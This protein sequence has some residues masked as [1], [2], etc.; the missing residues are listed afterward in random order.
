M[1][2]N[3]LNSDVVTIVRPMKEQVRGYAVVSSIFPRASPFVPTF[4]P[5][6]SLPRPLHCSE[7]FTSPITGQRLED[8]VPTGIRRSN[9][10]EFANAL[11]RMS[12]RATAGKGPEESLRTEGPGVFRDL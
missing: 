5:L 6:S 3:P 2:F 9:S 11:Q 1:M 12:K 8:I 10:Y 7:N 4:D